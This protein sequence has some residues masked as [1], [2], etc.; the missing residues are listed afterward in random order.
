MEK[1][2][3]PKR[4]VVNVARRVPGVVNISSEAQDALVDVCGEFVTLVTSEVTQLLVKDSKSLVSPEYIVSDLFGFGFGFGLMFVE[5]ML[6]VKSLGFDYSA[7]LD[8]VREE[9]QSKKKKAKLKKSAQSA[10][11]AEERLRLQELMFAQAADEMN[12]L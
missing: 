2:Q 5:Q 11:S 9:L 4:S 8:D 6:A 1:V 10:V 7:E 12:N 3:L